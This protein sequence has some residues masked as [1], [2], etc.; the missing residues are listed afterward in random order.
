MRTLPFWLGLFVTM[1]F[2]GAP[3]S[4]CFGSSASPC[5]GALRCNCYA[6]SS[7]N[8]GLSCRSNVCVVEPDDSG[9]PT[10]LPEDDAASTDE[11]VDDVA[12]QSDT[13]TQTTPDSPSGG[14][15]NVVTNGDFSQ[16]PANWGIV[17]GNGTFTAAGGKGCV[18]VDATQ[19]NQTV[20][21]GWPEPAGSPGAVL[22][23]GTSYTFSYSAS[24][25]AAPI[26][27]DAK[28]G[29]T[30]SPYN[31]DFENAADAVT[32]QVTPFTHTFTASSGD[33]S[34]G[35]AFAFMAA[36]PETVCFQNVS[37]VQN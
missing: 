35:I 17:A 27:V 33:P 31:A 10:P 28:V 4:G 8:A 22:L 15:T 29:Q 13:Q 9:T 6:N 24:S 11:P 36:A 2:L 14:G 30:T 26:S 37:L 16:G 5:Q 7:C 20:T 1:V 21:L 32:T 34:A 25:M 23:A 3:L 12:S 18:A 19:L